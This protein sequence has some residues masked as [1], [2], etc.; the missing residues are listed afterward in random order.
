MQ[1]NVV[2]FMVLLSVAALFMFGVLLV[3]LWRFC[4]R[5]WIGVLGIFFGAALFASGVVLGGP[6]WLAAIVGVMLVVATLFHHGGAAARSEQTLDD[7]EYHQD[8]K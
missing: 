3:W 5:D 1:H 8:V 2:L 6:W 4:E 7:V